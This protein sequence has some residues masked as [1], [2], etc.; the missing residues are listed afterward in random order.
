MRVSRSPCCAGRLLVGATPSKVVS[1]PARALGH[2]QG[3]ERC[4]SYSRSGLRRDRHAGRVR[5]RLDH[6]GRERAQYVTQQPRAGADRRYGRHECHR[7]RGRGKEGRSR[8]ELPAADKP[9]NTGGGLVTS[10]V[11]CGSTRLKRRAACRMRSCRGTFWPSTGGCSPGFET[12]MHYAYAFG[13]TP[14][15]MRVGQ[16]GDS[17]ALASSV[18]PE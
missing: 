12:R 18:V 9:I 7:D 15:W 1:R 8:G 3:R 4:A 5:H 14:P 11:I 16:P 2:H 10:R 17:C 6:Y 13:E